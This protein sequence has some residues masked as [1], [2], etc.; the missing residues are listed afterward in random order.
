MSLSFH[1]HRISNQLLDLSGATRCQ[2]ACMKVRNHLKFITGFG[3]IQSIRLEKVM[4]P[5]GWL[6]V[7][8][9]KTIL[10][11]CIFSVLEL[12]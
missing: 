6:L 5:V 12:V 9:P 8:W 2:R 7:K 11:Y 4:S 3:C 10:H 1:Q